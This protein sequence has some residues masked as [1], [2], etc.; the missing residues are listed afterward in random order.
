M[1]DPIRT[2]APHDEA[3][4]LLP[5]FATGQLDEADRARIERH[6]AACADCRRQLGV[7][8][9]LIHEFQSL[10]PEI[11]TSWARLRSQIEPR[12]PRQSRV[13]AAAA[14]FWALLSR[15]AVA[16]LAAA[17]LAFVVIAGGALLTLNRPAYHALG[18]AEV[19]ASANVL[20]I[21]RPE[22]TESEITDSLRASGARVVGGPTDA[23]AYLLHV[24][25]RQRHAAV[26]KLQ[27]NGD[28]LMVHPIDGFSK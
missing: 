13:A 7:E 22:A 20:V 5:W 19:S 16:A 26:A 11:D 17:Q 28:V 12:R 4:E 24:A 18:G 15:P 23:G 25:A 2:D 8:V 27:A 14:E 6:L 9:R 1:S 10:T 21:F 3:E